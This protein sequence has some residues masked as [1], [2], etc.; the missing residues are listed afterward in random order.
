MLD[1]DVEMLLAEK[2]GVPFKMLDPEDPIEAARDVGGTFPHYY[3]A[4]S[5]R[6]PG[7]A[8]VVKVAT[9]DGTRVPL[10]P[11]LDLACHS[12]DGFGWG[13]GG[14]GASQLALAILAD[15][16]DDDRAALEL[17]LAFKDRYVSRLAADRWRLTAP[18]LRVTLEA[19]KVEA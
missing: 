7:P 9:A 13:Y 2:A 16:L 12:P 4:R 11:R 15:F 19:L 17:H 8:A 14:S 5:H 10:D 18:G 3:G 6:G 1:V